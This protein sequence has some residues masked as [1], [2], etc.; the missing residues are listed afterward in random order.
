M[1][2]TEKNHKYSLQPRRL[3]DTQWALEP[4][5]TKYYDQYHNNGPTAMAKIWHE[6]S[7]EFEGKKEKG[8]V[9]SRAS[10]I[11]LGLVITLFP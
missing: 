11:V 9:Q 3:S 4:K 7:R 6:K 2:A 8:H 5:H 1:A 10:S